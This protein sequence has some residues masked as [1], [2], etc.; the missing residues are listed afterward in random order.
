MFLAT[1]MAIK[2]GTTF[3][4]GSYVCLALLQSDE[5]TL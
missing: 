1:Y 5:L 4:F 2:I 3:D